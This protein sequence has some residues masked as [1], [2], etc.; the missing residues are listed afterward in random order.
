MKTIATEQ[1]NRFELIRPKNRTELHAWIT[2]FLK[3]HM[4]WKSVC[5]NHSTPLDYPI[6]IH[7]ILRPFFTR[8]LC[9]KPIP[10]SDFPPKNRH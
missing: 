2:V 1:I 8:F 3:L 6:R 9:E 10:T 7:R 4:P 5:P